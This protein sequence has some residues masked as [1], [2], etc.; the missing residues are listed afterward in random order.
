[1]AAAWTSV[2][3]SAVTAVAA[4]GGVMLAQ[5]ATRTRDLDSRIWAPDLEARVTAYASTDILP[6]F[7]HCQWLLASPPGRD[8]AGD[9][10]WAARTLGDDIRDE[11]RTGRELREPLAFRL[12]DKREILRGI[13]VPAAGRRHAPHAGRLLQQEDDGELTR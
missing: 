11:L 12:Q 3:G 6:G 8:T 2:I 13:L 5:R 1:M 7:R 4:L 10:A 9:V